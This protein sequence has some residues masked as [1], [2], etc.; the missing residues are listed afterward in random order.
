MRAQDQKQ[1]VRYRSETYRKCH[2]VFKTSAYEAAKNIN[3]SRIEG[4]CMWVVEAP[5]YKQ[6]QQSRRGKLLCVSADPGCGKS[7]LSKWLIDDQL[8]GG[9]TSTI[10]YFFFKDNAGQKT[11]LQALCALLHQ[12]FCQKPGL[13]KHATTAWEVNGARLQREVDELWRIF[14]TAAADPSAG[15]VVCVLDALDECQ[16]TDRARLADFLNRFYTDSR[17]GVDETE[18][19]CRLWFLVTTRPYFHITS[20]F[21]DPPTIRLRGENENETISHEINLVI[22]VQ[23]S[24]LRLD[25]DS[26][27]ALENKL[28]SMTHRTYLWLYL[29]MEEVRNSLPYISKEIGDVIERI[30]ETVEEAYE[31]LLQKS[32]N[33]KAARALLHV[34][35]GAYRPL[36]L[37][38][39]KVAFYITASPSVGS[40]NELSLGQN[41]REDEICNVRFHEKIRTLCGLFVFVH[42]GYVYLI[43][44][45]AEEFLLAKGQERD[46]VYHWKHSLHRAECER[47]MAN[48]CIR[49]LLLKDFESLHRSG[50]KDLVYGRLSCPDGVEYGFYEYSLG[51]WVDHF[52][53]ARVDQDHCLVEMVLRLYD[54]QLES[55]REF[56]IRR[57]VPALPDRC[58]GGVARRD[59]EASSLY[60]A[61]FYEHWAAAR[62]MISMGHPDIEMVDSCH[63]TPLHWAASSSCGAM[64]LGPLL[65]A[66]KI[67]VNLVDN[68]GQTPLHVAARFGNESAAELLLKTGKVRLNARDCGNRT[69]LHLAV[70]SGKLSMLKLFLDIPKVTVRMKDA[71]GCTALHLAAA[72]GSAP[73]TKLLLNTGKINLSLKNDQDRTARETAVVAMAE[74]VRYRGEYSKVIELLD[75]FTAVPPKLRWNPLGPVQVSRAVP[76]TPRAS[77]KSER[78]ENPQR[79][80]DVCERHPHRR[81]EAAATVQNRHPPTRVL[82]CL[83]PSPTS[84]IP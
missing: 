44:Q 10:C 67:N 66:G 3:K 79:S 83:K 53:E 50:D 74:Y 27:M 40:Y 78:T 24:E 15:N 56:G 65:D 23:V 33:K 57:W 76:N 61:I 26:Q 51:S 48:A 32:T 43:H 42:D 80:L 34:I 13:L 1:E 69:P 45:T 2:Q 68:N 12:L 35:V 58:S 25:R 22:K 11:L 36:S 59:R 38:E 72:R 28:F 41:R 55:V 54:S 7:V 46:L 20:A 60:R 16:T 17:Q 30:P 49:Y 14:I 81:G 75:S 70:I 47:I 18:R 6:W 71:Q 5:E 29:V 4:T 52:R 84:V 8:R 82:C 77:P 9:E 19:R 64:V 37:A 31:R 39:L 21:D 63:A 73:M 62:R